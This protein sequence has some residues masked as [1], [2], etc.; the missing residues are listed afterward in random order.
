MVVEEEDE[1]EE[2]EEDDEDAG[3]VAADCNR[4]GPAEMFCVGECDAQNG[5]ES[6]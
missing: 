4:T 5:E 2:E 1:K 3:A 6:R